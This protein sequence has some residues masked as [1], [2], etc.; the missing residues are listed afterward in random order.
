MGDCKNT[1]RASFELRGNDG[2][3]AKNG[4]QIFITAR[5]IGLNAGPDAPLPAEACVPSFHPRFLGALSTASSPGDGI[6]IRT[7][8]ALYASPGWSPIRQERRRVHVVE[9]QAPRQRFYLICAHFYQSYQSI[10]WSP[11]REG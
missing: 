4:G 2:Q 10:Y 5:Y 7:A 8:L 11:E 1:T 6:H 9:K 3:R